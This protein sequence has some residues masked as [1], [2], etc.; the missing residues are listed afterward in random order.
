MAKLQLKYFPDD[1]L[2]TK[3]KK[4]SRFDSAVRKLAQDMLDTMY[5]SNGVGL[6]APQVGVSKRLMVIDISGED[7]PNKPIVFINPQIV[8]KS[9]ELVGLEGCLSFPGVFFE[10]KRANRVVVKFQNLSGKE[11]KLEAE[12]NLLCRAIQH[13]V[14]HLDGEVFIDK[15]VSRIAAE[16]EL[17][18]H[19]FGPEQ[20]V[21]ISQDGSDI[22]LLEHPPSA[23]LG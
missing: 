5:E 16:L 12:G 10:V 15:A 11:Q 9:G 7:E 17:S 4:I 20:P 21:S 3:T 18:K 19:G 8:E 13:E 23:V 2:A 6:A 22:T 1:V 14:D